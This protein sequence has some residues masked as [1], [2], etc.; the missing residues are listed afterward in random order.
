MKKRIPF[1][2]A[3]NIVLLV[4][5]STLTLAPDAFAQRGSRLRGEYTMLSGRIPGLEGGAVIYIIDAANQEF[6]AIQWNS[7]TKAFD[8][9]SHRDLRADGQVGP[10]R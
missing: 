9:I 5:L 2:V 1:L 4:A 3:V 6:A 7:A 10:G 8:I